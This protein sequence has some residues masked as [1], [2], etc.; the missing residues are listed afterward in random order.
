MPT[1]FFPTDL[2][3]ESGEF[4]DSEADRLS[5][6]NR[7]EFLKGYLRNEHLA[8]LVISLD[9]A[10]DHLDTEFNR[11]K[12]FLLKQ[13]HTGDLVWLAHQLKSAL[14]SWGDEEAHSVAAREKI[15]LLSS[16]L[17]KRIEEVA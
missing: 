9:E 6:E 2:M 17:D 15:K 11:D 12:I 8:K 4:I 14:A 7:L 1:D 5:R 3:D 16:A 13:A 10:V